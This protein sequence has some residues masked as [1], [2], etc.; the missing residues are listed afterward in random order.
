M[1]KFLA[2][3]FLFCFLL[4][5]FNSS[6]IPFFNKNKPSTTPVSV[7]ID[8]SKKSNK[9]EIDFRIETKEKKARYEPE[10][11]TFE[12][13]FV[14]Y[15]PRYDKSSKYYINPARQYFGMIGA[16]RKNFEPK[17][18]KEEWKEIISDNIRITKLVGG[19]VPNDLGNPST[20]ESPKEFIDYPAV[21]IPDIHLTIVS[22]NY[23][24]HKIVYDEVLEVKKHPTIAGYFDKYLTNLNLKP[25]TY[26]AIFAVTSDAPEFKGTKARLMIGRY[27]SKF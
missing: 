24:N 3:I 27:R 1:K 7:P 22:L 25:G 17:Y 15:D 5:P 11:T 4:S 12:L 16:L 23:A 14:P 2:Q 10:S 21:P 9:A 20:G 6:A 18:T 26:R 19:S 8:I 13:E